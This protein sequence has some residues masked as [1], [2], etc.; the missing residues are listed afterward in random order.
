MDAAGSLSALDSPLASAVSDTTG[1]IGWEAD[2][3][4]YD[5][6]WE[7]SSD[8]NA[9]DVMDSQCPQQVPGRRSYGHGIE[10][11]RSAPYR[12]YPIK[13]S[14]V[15]GYLKDTHGAVTKDL[16]IGL[17]GDV[18]AACPRHRRPLPPTRNQKRTKGGLTAWLDEHV[19]FV[20]S[21]IVSQQPH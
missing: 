1:D 9:S 3:C 6:E 11:I 19:M 7:I 20:A 8:P 14:R 5:E 10:S 15:I 12:H 18:L 17:I 4:F 2:D 21:F 13:E 16:L